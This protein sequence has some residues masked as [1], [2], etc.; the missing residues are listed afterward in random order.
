MFYRSIIQSVFCYCVVCWYGN[1]S[2]KDKNVINRIVKS[3]R[4]IGVDAKCVDELYDECVNTKMS[5]ILVKY[6][7]TLYNMYT[8]LPSGRLSSIYCRTERFK[9]SF[10]PTSVRKFN[11]SVIE[12]FNIK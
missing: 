7:H 10:V 11:K 9:K 3:A 1:L 8:R 2:N 6:D 12:K 4:R 5:N